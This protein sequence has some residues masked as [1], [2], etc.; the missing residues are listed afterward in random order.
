MYTGLRFKGVVKEQFR[1]N[2]G[3]IALEGDWENSDDARF[4][5]FGNYDRASFIP[6]GMLAYMP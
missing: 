2:F 4:K 3:Q 1:K 6:C 5:E